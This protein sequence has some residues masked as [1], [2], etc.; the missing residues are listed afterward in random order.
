MNFKKVK[1]EEEKYYAKANF[2]YFCDR[3]FGIHLPAHQ[4]VWANIADSL[5]NHIIYAPAA[6]GKTTL[7]CVLRTIWKITN[8]RFKRFIIASSTDTLSSEILSAV[9]YQLMNNEKL[10]A[11]FG[12]YYS[13]D[14]EWTN[15]GIRVLQADYEVSPA[16]WKPSGRKDP[17]VRAVG[18]GTAC[19]G[20]RCDE[21]VCDDL[22][23]L[24]NSRGEELRRSIRY[25][26]WN[27]LEPTVDSGGQVIWVGN[28]V[29]RDDLSQELIRDSEYKFHCFKA[30]VDEYRKKVLWPEKR[31]YE[32]L[33]K[34]RERD[35]ISFARRFQSVPVS[36]SDYVDWDK[37]AQ[38]FRSDLKLVDFLSFSEREKYK[39]VVISVDPAFTQKRRSSYSAII[40][41]GLTPEKKLDIIGIWKGKVLSDDLKRIIRQKAMAFLVHEVLL[42]INAQQWVLFHDLAK[43]PDMPKMVPCYT[44]GAKDDPEVGISSVIRLIDQKGIIL[45]YGDD[46]SRRMVDDLCNEIAEYPDGEHDDLFMS[47]YQGIRNLISVPTEGERTLRT[48]HYRPKVG[49]KILGGNYRFRF[50]KPLSGLISP[51]LGKK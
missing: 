1:P 8:D 45:R 25:W 49:Y 21:L 42:E 7:F 15:T 30:I 35:P 50:A 40:T 27:E 24:K 33:A 31:S 18:V 6:H 20:K 14:C 9:S 36:D 29:H 12:P 2:E 22:I 48:E 46:H 5:G 39:K 41:M 13:T 37:M 19:L 44:S 23:N 16:L 26:F 43:L 51:V 17:T 32:W 38:N 4:V 47:L 28:P 3:Y 10:I 34:R 11:D